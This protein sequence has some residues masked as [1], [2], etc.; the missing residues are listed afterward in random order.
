MQVKAIWIIS[1]FRKFQKN[2]LMHRPSIKKSLYELRCATASDFTV[3]FWKNIFFILAIF[4]TNNILWQDP[5]NQ[6]WKANTPYQFVIKHR[7]QTG[8]INLQ[9]YEGSVIIGEKFVL[10]PAKS[11]IS[12]FKL[13]Q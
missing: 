4:D 9:I 5:L 13:K 8:V 2:V 6:G 1:T 11:Q 3:L 12:Y 7:P 10:L